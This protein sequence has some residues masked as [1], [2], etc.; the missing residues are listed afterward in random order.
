M[1]APKA[2]LRQGATGRFDMFPK[3]KQRIVVVMCRC[4]K[5]TQVFD[6]RGIERG[7]RVG[8]GAMSF[9]AHEEQQEIEQ[10]LGPGC[11]ECKHGPTR[12]DIERVKL[13]IFL[14]VRFGEGECECLRFVVAQTTGTAHG[15][16]FAC[17]IGERLS[18]GVL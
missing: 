16:V 11:V 3:R 12:H 8:L 9:K 14:D 4:P 5:G 15:E 13:V 10:G 18:L 2:T 7:D 17:L 1:E 6:P